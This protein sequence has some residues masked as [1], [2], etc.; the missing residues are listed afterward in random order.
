MPESPSPPGDATG[1]G[2]AAQP[3]GGSSIPAALRFRNKWLLLVGVAAAIAIAVI[4]YKGRVKATGSI[5]MAP[6][7]L[8]SS[9]RDDLA[10]ASSR[11]FG[12]YRCEFETGGAVRATP[13]PEHERLVP[14][15]TTDRQ[16]YLVPNIFG[17][18]AVAGRYG[19]E[20]PQGKS[21]DTLKRFTANCELKL[22]EKVDGTAFE[23]RWLR[24]EKFNPGIS[25][26]VAELVNCTID[27]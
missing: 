7:T 6:I 17:Q 10:C 21:R 9:D 18:P 2:D 24:G 4:V 12:R 25:G 3:Q 20:V 19:T 8:I 26:W 23:V 13:T 11:M 15:F 5:V 16:M 22:L 14:V 1:T 27:G